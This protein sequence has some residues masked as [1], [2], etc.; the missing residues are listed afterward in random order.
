MGR[1]RSVYPHAQLI[2]GKRHETPTWGVLLASLAA[3]AI[4]AGAAQASQLIDRN[5]TQVSMKANAKGEQPHTT[6]RRQGEARARLGSR[7]RD[8]SDRM[9][10]G[11]VQARLLGRGTA[12]ITARHWDVFN[13]ACLSVRG[14]RCVERCR[15]QGGR[16][17]WA[18]SPGSPP[19]LRGRRHR[20]AAGVGT[21]AL[22]LGRRSAGALADDRLGVSQVRPRPSGRT[23]TTARG[24]SFK[25]TSGAPLDSFG[26]NIYV[27]VHLAY[28]AGWKRDNS[29][30]T[31][32]VKGSFCY[33]F[34]PHG[35]H[36]AGRLRYRATAKVG[37]RGRDV[38]GESPART[39]Q[40]RTALQ[41][42]ASA[43]AILRCKPN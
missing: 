4:A 7:E 31:H 27:D 9:Q 20:D 24:S 40:R 3:A 6:A 25:S 11:G 34:Y 28:G 14:L 19:R 17:R 33:G 12:S 41:Q 1:G 18:C 15:V 26:R 2:K 32:K 39:T 16:R 30:L 35:S 42:R 23:P 38:A 36:P 43:L 8:C 37:R 29:F 5:A 13:G 10:A 21:E 22:A